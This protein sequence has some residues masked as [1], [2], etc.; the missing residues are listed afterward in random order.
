MLT[1]CSMK[2]LRYEER[3]PVVS[4]PSLLI[5]P[6]PTNKTISY[7]PCPNRSHTL[8]HTL[9]N[10]PSHALSSQGNDHATANGVDAGMGGVTRWHE[11]SESLAKIAEMFP[12]VNLGLRDYWWM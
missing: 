2:T 7:K 3:H 1:M 6:C 11:M 5:K 4:Y 8:L 10:T 9:P 12:T